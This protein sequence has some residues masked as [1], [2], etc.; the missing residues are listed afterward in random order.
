ME[1]GQGVTEVPA[2]T[3]HR[4]MLYDT[5]LEAHRYAEFAGLSPVSDEVDAMERAAS[6]QRLGAI[7]VLIAAVA[8]MAHFLADTAY[9]LEMDK[10]ERAGQPLGDEESKYVH[11]SM[12]MIAC[13]AATGTISGLVDLGLLVVPEH[14]AAGE[15]HV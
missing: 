13:S 3:V 1:R 5:M 4:Q 12:F 9:A 6:E 7:A 10:F 14:V 11:D 2:S 15:L 8:D